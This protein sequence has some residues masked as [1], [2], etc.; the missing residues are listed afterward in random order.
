MKRPRVVALASAISR[1][2]A[3]LPPQLV[4]AVGAVAATAWLGHGLHF[5]RPTALDV[6]VRRAAQVRRLDVARRVLAPLF[7]IGL[8]GGYIT[9]AYATSH[10]LR[11]GG[12][13]GGRAI[14]TAAWLGWLVHR[15]VKL[16]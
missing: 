6:R 7:P 8:P 14:V 9:I 11:R 5:Y 2:A 4:I 13:R 15:A 10:W 12:R 1:D 16:G 3:R